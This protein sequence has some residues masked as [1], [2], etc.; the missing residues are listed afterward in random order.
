MVTPKYAEQPS[1]RE[2]IA[3]R[4]LR[5]YPLK[6]G[7]GSLA[8]SKVFSIISGS[9]PADLW[10]QVDGGEALVPTT[11]LV[12]RS[13]FFAGDLDP[14]ISWV[15]D[16]FARH[17]DVALDIGANLGLVTLRLAKR[18]GVSGKVHAFEPNPATLEYLKATLAR[19]AGL[20]IVLHEIGLGSVAATLSLVAERGNAGTASFVNAATAD[21]TDAI[22][23]PVR[24]LDDYLPE[25]GIRAVDF[26]K[27]D[28]EGFEAEVLRGGAHSIETLRPRAIV[29]EE[30]GDIGKPTLPASLK[31]ISDAGYAIFG[32]PK[33]FLSVEMV[34]L[35][36]M[37]NLAAHDFVALRRDAVPV[38]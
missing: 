1:F 6:S 11:D 29:L 8:T 25:Q 5:M 27:I 37:R 21:H 4:L 23:V 22:D 15:V 3:A 10:A 34:P 16:R 2:A 31:L 32:L 26:I 35:E 30:H 18:V 14:K 9:R 7:C 24:R 36:N 13:M 12:G 33:R 17:G 38:A 28:V 19:N 20:P